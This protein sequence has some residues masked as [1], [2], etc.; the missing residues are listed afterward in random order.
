MTRASGQIRSVRAAARM[1]RWVREVPPGRLAA[2]CE[3]ERSERGPRAFF[4]G[5]SKSD[6]NIRVR[7]WAVRRRFRRL[8]D[9]GGVRSR[10]ALRCSD[11][12]SGVPLRGLSS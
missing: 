5:P 9:A 11:T 2:S 8:L 7:R 6:A 4:N 3:V 10:C 12:S 1:R